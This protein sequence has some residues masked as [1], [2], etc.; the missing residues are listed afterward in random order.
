[1]SFD[2]DLFVIGVGSA[3][4]AAAKAAAK[5][6]LR[7]G[8]AEQT[9]LGGTC[10][11]RGCI[12]KKLIVYA[13]DF[14][15]NG[16]MAEDYGW[17]K[18]ER[19]FNW[20]KFINSVHQHINN[21]NESYRQTLE[22]LEI[23]LFEDRASF[24]DP[25][26]VKVGDKEV[27]ADKILIAVGGQPF[28]PDLPGIE[29]GITS[30]EMF[31]LPHLPKQLAIVGGGYIGVEFSSMMNA[32][33]CEV[34][35]IDSD[36]VV[37]SGF[38]DDIRR[39]VHNGLI[40]RGVEFIG[41]S[42]AKEIKL[43]EDK[44][45]LKL[46]TESEDKSEKIITADTVL[47][48]TGRVPNTSGLNLESV[49]VELEE[50]G[51]IKV[52]CYSQT[53]Q[54]NIFAVGD[55]TDRLQLTPAAKAEAEA[56]ISTVFAKK[57]KTIDY[58][59]I[60]CAVFARPEASSIGMTETQAKEKFGD[61]IKCYKAEFKPLIYQLTTKEEQIIIKVVVKGESEEVVGIHMVGEHAADI[62]QSL[63]VAFRKGMTKQDLDDAIAIH[64][65]TAEEILTL[66]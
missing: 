39:G 13:A 27:T 50:K 34:T 62:I 30:R 19:H 65:T 2:Y 33:G 7:V 28:K 55:C 18:C 61:V 42:R 32:F 51:S 21:I 16:K 1:M 38:D 9:A 11:N 5:R 37:L 29:Y 6:N 20:T 10:L 12:P 53:T 31:K 24:V 41:N 17:N 56:F 52:D 45:L 46:N 60:P 36:K 22:K 23:K 63:G 54:E 66:G 47:I 3:G 14:A 15:L 58:G 25:H 43:C 64:P 44:L 49:G 35:L 4:A 57:P 8:V 48:A 59:L 26:K 40:Q